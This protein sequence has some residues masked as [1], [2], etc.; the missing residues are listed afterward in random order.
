MF[1]PCNDCPAT[2]YSWRKTVCCMEHSA[3]F[4]AMLE[5]KRGLRTKDEARKSLENI[6]DIDYNNTA[7]VIVDEIFYEPKTEVKTI[8][9]SEIKKRK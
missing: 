7:K 2:A 9:K 5:Y 4:I 6:T 1:E 8:V 3:P